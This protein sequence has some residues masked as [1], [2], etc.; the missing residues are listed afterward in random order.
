MTRWCVRFAWLAAV[1]LLPAEAYAQ[2]VM[3]P[4]VDSD[5][6]VRV[7]NPDGSAASFPAYG[8][9]C[10]GG[11]RVALGD[12]N[13]DGIVDIIT[14]AG[15]TG[16]PHVRVFSGVDLSE[17]ASFYAYDP[18]FAGGIFVAAG[19]V[20]GDGRA[21][22]ITGAG[23]G[24]G[25][26]VKVFSGAD[27]SVLASFFAYSPLHLGGVFVAAGDVNGDGRADIITGAG[28]GGGP[29]VRAFSG[30]DFSE[31]ASFYAYNPIFA[32]GVSVASVDFNGDGLADII[33]GAGPTGGPHVRVFSGG[34]LAELA[35]F[36][37]YDPLFRGGVSVA[38]AD[39]DGDGQP[40]LV[41]GAGPGGGPHVKIFR[42]P[43]LALVGSFYA[44][45]PSYTGGVYVGSLAGSAGVHFT[46]PSATT[47]TVGV[48]GTFTIRTSGA[49]PPVT[50]TVNGPLPA[51]VTFTDNGDGTATL[52]GTPAVGS[53]GSYGLTFTV[54]AGTPLTAS[55][56]QNLIQTFTQSFTLTVNEAPAITSAAAT[57][58][59]IGAAGTFAVTTSG[60]PRPGITRSGAALPA[61][62][63]W[64]DNG[65]GTGTLSGTPDASGAGT[66]V[67]TFT[68][69]NGVGPATTQSF[70]L[71]VSGAPSFTSAAT[72]TFT[73]GSA[74]TF[75]VT[76]VATPTATL[77][78]TGTLPAG[79]TFVDSGNGTGM[80][81]GT[82][83]AGTG[84]TYPLTFT[85]T[86]SVG[87]A[88]QA[89]TLTVHQAPAITSSAAAT[90]TVGLPGTFTVTTTGLP[91]ASLAVSGAALP[92]GVTFTDNGNGT[93]TLSGTPAAGT[94]GTYA[95]TFTATNAVG[96]SA[97]Q[98]F[99]LT[100]N[101]T[102]AV[103]SVAATTFARG[104]A[105]TFTVTTTGFPVP[106]LSVTGLPAG[107]TFVDNLNG[108]GTL[109]G[110]PAVGTAGVHTLTLTVTNGV[111]APIV[112]TFTLTI[113]EGPVITS[114][115][116]AT[117]AIGAPNS[118]TVTAS[119]F[120]APSLVQGGAALPSGV[121][122]T[123]NGNGTGT[124]TGTPAAGT[125][126]TYALTFTATNGSGSA[127]QN[128]ILN[129]IGSPAFTSASTTTFTVGAAGTFTVTA[130]GAPTPALTVAGALPSGVTFADNGNGTGTLSGTPAAGT[131]GAHALTFI[132]ANGVLPDATQSF[133]LNV[134]QAP[135]ITS[136]ASA[137]FTIGVAGS[138]TV[139]TSGFP[140]PSLAIGGAALPSGLNF[141]DNGTG[142]GTLS[143]TP[144]A[145]TGGT[146]AIT[147]TASNVPGTSAPQAFTLTVNGPPSITSA[148]TTTF[149]VGSAGSFTV[150]S[151]GSPTPTLSVS[152]TLP[153]GVT[154]TPNPDGTGTLSGTPAAGTGGTYALAFT[155]SNGVL[156]NA[157]QAFTL[158]V[159]QAPAVTS[160]N[161][162]TFTVGT[163]GSFSVTTS[164]FP[165][166]SIARGG[167]ALP[168]GVTFTDN[169][170]GTGTLTGTPAAGTGG[171]YAISFTAT[172]TVSASAPQAFTLTVN[173]AP[174][175]TSANTVNFTVGVA[176]S[177]SVTT[178]GFPVPTLARGGV[179]LPAGLTFVDNLNG[180]GT[181]AGT[182]A[183]G[184]GGSYAITFT[185]TN[186]VGSSPVQAFTLIV[187]APPAITSAASTT[188]TV[189]TPGTFT[190]TATG[191]PVP[192][193]SQAGTL[194]T[195]ITFTPATNVLGGTATQTGVFPLVF[196]AT[197]AVPPDATQNFT[198]NVVCPAI[199]VNPA[200][201][202]EGLF[203][204]A[205]PGVTFTQT[206]STG[207]TITWS[208]TGLPAGLSI[209]STTGIVSGTPT[210]TVAG[211][212]VVV[213]ATD[214]FGCTGT[215]STTITVR[216]TTD[217]ENYVNG[218]GNT[219]YI[220]GAIA[221]GIPLTPNVFFVDNVKDGDNGPGTLS[222]TFPATSANG[223]IAERATDGTFLYTPNVGFGG[224]SDTFTYT[225]TDGNGVTNTGTVTINLATLVWYVNS[226]AGAGDGRSHNPFNTLTAAG[227]PSAS[228]S[229]IYVHTG[230]GAT[231]GNLT[232]D[233]TQ[234]LR[235]QGAPFS[236][237]GLTIAGAPASA[238]SL[239]GTVTLANGTQVVGVNFAPVGIPALV[240]SGTTLGI[241]ID[242]VN[243]TGGTNALS[244]TNATGVVNVTNS[245]FTNS[246]G[247]E[248]LISGGTGNVT[249]GATISSNAGRSIDIQSR[250]SGTVTFTGAITDTGG[251]GILLNNNGTSTFSFSGGMTLNGAG[252]T[253]TATNPSLAGTLTITGTNTIGAT[254]PPTSGTALNVANINIGAG[255]LTFRSVSQNG[256]ASGIVLNTTGTS[257]RL[258]VTGTGSTTRGGDASGGLIQNTTSHG[259]SLTNTLNP[260]FI[261]MSIQNTSGSGIDGTQVASFTFDNGTINNSAT[262]GGADESN[263]S[264]D[265]QT[266]GTETNISGAVTITD[267]ILTNSRWHGVRILNYNGTI[268]DL[269]VSNNTIT[270]STA[271]ASSLGSGIQVLINGSPTTVANLT[272]ATISGNTITNFPSDGGIEVKGG[273]STA[274]GSGGTMGTPG[275]ATDIISITGNLIAGASAANRMGTSFIDIG[276]SGGN[277]ASR[278]QA[279]FDISNNGTALNPLQHSAGIGIGLGNTGYSTSTVT[280]NNNRIV[281]NNTVASAGIG[282]GNGLVLSTAETP[283]LTWT[284]QNNTISQTDGN[285]ILAVAR[286][287]N[288]IMKVK[289]QNNTVAAPLTGVR[290]GIRVDAG[291][292]T[293]G[294]DAAVCV[295]MSGNTSAG[296]GGTQGLGLRKQGTTPTTNDFGIHGLPGGSTATPN[297]EAYVN[298]QNPAGGGTLLISA[299]SGFSTCSLP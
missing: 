268:S 281:A 9:A 249:I 75:T 99:T 157:T 291:N 115:S 171:T 168:A 167:V 265:V 241:V 256:G 12:V 86:N 235:G 137:T 203:M 211:A 231:T 16:G 142:T 4:G 283:D 139:T 83:A 216:P 164:G 45:D 170:N 39:F 279:N 121:Q 288:G 228:G 21:D 150:T 27:L 37:A 207:S 114:A 252:T 125:G 87:S 266:L 116:S 218:V 29:H 255:G 165:V 48:P 101:Q 293:A 23:A 118:F 238:P 208:A 94:G 147:F 67:I 146:Y 162:A 110:T 89:F 1:S 253:F 130:I 166:P 138:F 40:E 72:A 177:F 135:A 100:V 212:A 49:I 88:T 38:A 172:N 246:S 46:S 198:L 153:T 163:L 70:T 44:F 239:S 260:S 240:A 258:M 292:N 175:I 296:S 289:I 109:S 284:I 287:I 196:T 154:F 14:G 178:S 47:F 286:A 28:P 185:A 56:S 160:A 64:V 192:T 105:G 199:T 183:A 30:A 194:P 55:S 277:S 119:G 187:Q 273:N 84:G 33:T 143:G 80:L 11:V 104:V 202:P 290:P 126:G 250:T 248:V 77:S 205:Y 232:M 275:S 24:G 123:D 31:L 61:G 35:G 180:S 32:G 140:A 127:V 191:F 269:N 65:D 58:F 20:N 174:A 223:T 145:G 182:P 53:G 102:A 95:I 229:Y 19:D 201:M 295:N 181:L 136:A 26:H 155:A 15:P 227:T 298:G 209:G 214:N 244:L 2:V 271:I 257:G 96:S 189:G 36:F 10:R 73:V 98:T 91:T 242:T 280:M 141:T 169:G 43:D 276:I 22:I 274:T 294:E 200:T 222:V 285:G 71:T 81:S 272:R 204:V 221:D 133:T 237:N 151:T 8:A 226:A 131:G 51:G 122:F 60:F 111:G 59:T 129:V 117:F 3:A 297:V 179:A 282:G 186:T 220:V 243:V 210:T 278:S 158:I 149:T 173:Q 97:P 50:I 156:P 236:L 134:N 13:G 230:S 148:N 263:L 195:G 62:V 299:T 215:R 197:N 225:L 108:T 74:G 82:P 254:T 63:T 159:N 113:T 262:G 217:N 85:A 79:V 144:A 206:G 261:N 18:I 41:T 176:G 251:T 17:L 219:Q 190:V 93:G 128:F 6:V 184:T 5:P 69:D 7:L 112:V 76:T 68:A 259:I 124:L 42:V 161:S 66:H 247:A 270:S 193:V 54:T 107:V 78:L 264:F 92:G 120:P 106:T 233:T 132:A 103:T 234:F 25:P 245:S 152:G 90:F 213:T 267:S 57:N 188:F 52:A 34:N 224:P